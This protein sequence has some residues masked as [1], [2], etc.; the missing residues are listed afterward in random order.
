MFESGNFQTQPQDT[1]FNTNLGMSNVGG[2]GFNNTSFNQNVGLGGVGGNVD[3][4]FIMN[5]TD[6]L[7]S[8]NTSL[9]DNS[10]MPDQ[11]YALNTGV[12]GTN[13]LIVDPTGAYDQTYNPA[14]DFSVGAD[15]PFFNQDLNGLNGVGG[16][17]PAYGGG[18]GGSNNGGGII[19]GTP[20]Y[21]DDLD[22]SGTGGDIT[23]DISPEIDYTGSGVDTGVTAPVINNAPAINP[24]EDN[25]N[26]QLDEN[27]ATVPDIDMQ[28][29]QGD[30]TQDNVP[31][32]T[33]PPEGGY[34]NVTDP[35]DLPNT[36]PESNTNNPTGVPIV[37]TPPVS[38]Q[39]MPE[40]Q[41]TQGYFEEVPSTY[42]EEEP[43]YQ[44]YESPFN[45]AA[46]TAGL[47]D[48]FNIADA[49]SAPQVNSGSGDNRIQR[50]LQDVPA[51]ND[52]SLAQEGRQRAEDFMYNQYKSR[53]D[54]Q[55]Q[56][57]EQQLQIDLRN[58]GLVEGDAAYDAAMENFGR[59]RNDAY[60]Q[61]KFNAVNNAGAEAQRNFGMES[62][63]RGQLFGEAQGMSQDDISRLN[64]DVQNSQI[65]MQA[66]QLSQQGRFQE[67]QMMMDKARMEQMGMF[68]QGQL[69][70]QN[71]GQVFNQEMTSANYQN[72][73]RAQ[74]AQEEMARRSQTLNELN[75]F[76]NGQ[77]VSQPNFSGYNQAG[78]AGGTNYFGAAQ[79]GYNANLNSFNANQAMLQGLMSG[80]AGIYSAG[81][82]G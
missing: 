39:P 73:L 43:V 17:D 30:T 45:L 28:P 81:M 6:N 26:I 12:G 61:A 1:R 34:E 74:Q 47:P 49:G 25:P 10:F 48:Q 20:V 52:I 11:N 38:Q 27:N 55:F 18:F 57:A 58:R 7:S 65:A 76:L 64:I 42:Q 24:V 22:F 37:N 8:G 14:I 67:A 70:L 44:A 19:G 4:P 63:R 32:Y 77:Q 60:Q 3:S 82:F 35:V 33:N 72:S 21:G 51:L 23:N 5:P 9:I 16:Y 71:R 68:Q 53:L 62:S 80:G 59:Q 56:E 15:D 41:Y 29:P 66:K 40:T 75:A 79:E 54:P 78:N 31:D 46:A 69:D 13:S 2:I 50:Y 36:P